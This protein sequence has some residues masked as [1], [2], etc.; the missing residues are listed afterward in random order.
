MKIKNVYD[1]VC[2][3]IVS[4]ERFQVKARLISFSVKCDASAFPV[5]DVNIVRCVIISWFCHEIH[6]TRPMRFEHSCFIN[7]G[8]TLAYG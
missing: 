8:I 1:S 3:F 4:A 7:K 5:R 2:T 6:R